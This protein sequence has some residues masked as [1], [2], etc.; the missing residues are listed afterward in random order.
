MFLLR[1]APAPV[2]R[3]ASLLWISKCTLFVCGASAQRRPAGGAFGAGWAAP[4]ESG[5]EGVRPRVASGSSGGDWVDGTG[6]V[7]APGPVG[8]AEFDVIGGSS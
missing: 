4:F 8:L 5:L 1:F 3:A 7:A 2:L 6:C